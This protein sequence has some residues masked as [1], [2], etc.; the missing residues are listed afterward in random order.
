MTAI[1]IL[2]TNILIIKGMSLMLIPLLF[3]T[4]LSKRKLLILV[5][6]LTVARMALIPAFEE[7][8]IEGIYFVSEVR[9][10]DDG[11]L[12]ISHDGRKYLADNRKGKLEAFS[13]YIIEGELIDFA[14]KDQLTGFSEDE[15]YKSLGFS[16]RAEVKNARKKLEGEMNP[17][18]KLGSYLKD[19]TE[20]IYGEHSSLVYTLLFGVKG[21]MDREYLNALSILG[22]SHLFVVSGFHMGIIEKSLKKLFSFLLL[23]YVAREMLSLVLLMILAGLTGFHPSALRSVHVSFLRGTAGA[24]GRKFDP[25]TA[26]GSFVI[27]MLIK[28]PYLSISYSFLMG[29]LA[30]ASIISLEGRSVIRVMTGIFPILIALSPLVGVFVFA[31]NYIFM[32][33][34]GILVPILYMGLLIPQLGYMAGYLISGLDG[35]IGY[36]VNIS[37]Y[38]IHFLPFTAS[39]L[40]IY[41][42]VYIG[43]MVKGENRLLHD[44]LVRQR[45]MIIL[46]TLLSIVLNQMHYAYSMRDSITFFDVGQGDS[47][48]IITDKGRTILID[49]G[50]D[51]DIA[52]R[53]KRMGV[54]VIDLVIIS[55]HHGDHDGALGN[56]QYRSYVDYESM[57]MGDTLSLDDVKLWCIGS[58]AYNDD[59]NDRSIVMMAEINGYRTLFTG[60]IGA[61]GLSELP[62]YRYDVLKVPHHGSL[63]SLYDRL[64]RAGRSIAV[65]SVGENSYGHPS[66]EVLRSLENEG[67]L[68]FTT[69]N[70][71]E[72]MISFKGNI[73]VKASRGKYGF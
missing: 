48:L 60:D 71:G 45:K 49:T 19:R 4:L 24:L 16:G 35:L 30:Y 55:H 31:F 1:I 72:I 21:L 70:E 29:T 32:Y 54:S 59:E 6:I 11:R 13:Y 28:N 10:F 5:I 23:P 43:Y 14:E 62:V 73:K 36:A 15:Y 63:Y 37:G 25:L 38:F 7:E 68:V 64:Y 65:V 33:L 46:V 58:D 66:S 44:F 12:S 42:L 50:N 61:E 67:L 57:K 53:L 69:I 41:Y 39:S 52:I 56:L 26:V 20:E 47:A 2:V 40:A 27:I 22:I 17:L 51:K 34:V 8:H 9:M 3:V 18:R